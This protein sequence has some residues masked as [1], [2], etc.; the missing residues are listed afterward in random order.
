MTFIYK[1]T[2]FICSHRIAAAAFVAAVLLIS[3]FFAASS[4][5]RENIFD[6]LPESDDV[7]KGHLEVSEIF[8]LS[9]TLYF[10]ISGDSAEAACG[11]LSQKLEDC[12]KFDEVFPSSKLGDLDSELIFLVLSAPALFDE[13]FEAS[14]SKVLSK[15]SIKKR[16]EFF[17]RKLLTPV[18][19]GY[20]Q[21]FAADVPGVLP[22]IFDRLKS[23]SGNFAVADSVNGKLVSKDGKN[24]LVAARGKFPSS[25]SVRSAEIAANAAQVVSEVA[26][27]YPGV[28]IAWC[29]GYRMA[30]DNAE[31]ARKD[32]EKCLAAT[33]L[34]MFFLCLASFRRVWFAPL[35]LLPSLFGTAAAFGAVSEFYGN[36]STIAV[37]FAGIAIGVSIDYAVH[38]LYRLDSLDKIDKNSACETSEFYAK[39]IVIVAGTTTAAFLIICFSGSDEFAQLGAFGAAGVVFSALASLFLLPPLALNA[40]APR[41]RN[42]QF[43]QRAAQAVYPF[44]MSHSKAFACLAAAAF[45][46]AVPFAAGLKFDGRISSFNGVSESAAKDDSIVRSVWG[47]A[48]SKKFIA[49]SA[50]TLD[51]ANLKNLKLADFLS[52]CGFVK[53][54]NSVSLIVPDCK[55]VRLNRDRWKNFW[56]TN[57]AE[58]KENF[59]AA[60]AETGFN[61][62]AFKMGFDVLNDSLA[63]ES[64]PSKSGILGALIKSRTTEHEGKHWISTF[65][66]LSENSSSEAFFCSLKE[67][68]PDAHYID[69]EFMGEHISDL[70]SFW[71]LRYCGAAFAAVVVYLLA[72]LRSF[73]AVIAVLAP[74]GVGMV[75]SFAV[76]SIAGMSINLI[77]VIFVIFAVCVAQDYGVFFIFERPN[78]AVSTMA[79]VSISA[80]TTVAAF[81]TLAFAEHPVLRSLGAAAAVSI[82]S[83]FL[84]CAFIMPFMKIHF[85]KNNGRS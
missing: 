82:L 71:M 35:A 70:T 22:V 50:G 69:M 44:L 53:S 4:D 52:G 14:L 60:A 15:N 66:E 41:G 84:A 81:G 85:L 40:P 73:R 48:I 2:R 67:A 49:V 21:A 47:G 24:F 20:K 58:F 5:F 11:L 80:A 25:D 43:F 51:E 77:N 63:K 79:A 39:P 3:G 78:T 17:K 42:F 19:Y 46:A 37:A 61:P 8:G 83:I 54:F 31:I 16:M 59:R 72:M 56:E 38:I 74:V 18:S 26:E 13:H 32:S 64:D 76:M 75:W 57:M 29:G 30:A 7:V 9:D 45:A 27:A 10:N 12:G 28:E 62:G 34:L 33:L 23:A 36:V 1:T 6:L 68:F 55:S 65:V